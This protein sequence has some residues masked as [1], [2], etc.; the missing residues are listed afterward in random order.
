MNEK[1]IALASS[2]KAR[3]LYWR[4]G[5]CCEMFKWL[6]TCSAVLALFAI[7]YVL[8]IG[9]MYWLGFRGVFGQGPVMWLADVYAPVW[10]LEKTPL[11]DL[12]YWYVYLGR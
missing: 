1:D 2:G 4:C 10:L 7:L 6:T 11:K 8:S 9:P 5:S 3:I 12:L